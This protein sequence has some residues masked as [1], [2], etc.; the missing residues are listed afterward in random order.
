[1]T[2]RSFSFRAL[3]RLRADK[4]GATLVEFGLVATPFIFLLM[5]TLD[6]GYQAYL[7]SLAFGVLE[8]AARKAAVGGVTQAQTEAYIRTK[9]ANIL[10]TTDAANPASITVTPRSYSDFGT[11][12]GGER[13]TGDTAP[14][15]SYNSTDCYE[16][17]NNNGV[18]DS[19][20]TGAA[21][22]GG[23][24][25]VAYYQLTVNVPRLLPVA[26]LAGWS[27][28]ITVT[29]KTLIRNQPYAEQTVIIR[30]S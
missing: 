11:L 21:S 6:L 7:R 17:R 27:N 26:S 25:D 22:G 1:M 24:D 9:M 4:R 15:G 28:N 19:V 12:T 14:V 20:S 23:A 10:P 29:A 18:W 2:R 8:E 30:C 13:I 3:R 16:D 5:G